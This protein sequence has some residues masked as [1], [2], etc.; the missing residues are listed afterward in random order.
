M[1]Q[2][3]GP[4]PSGMMSAWF[5]KEKAVQWMKTRVTDQDKGLWKT[6]NPGCVLC[7]EE[8]KVNRLHWKPGS[9]LRRETVLDGGFHRKHQLRRSQAEP[10]SPATNRHVSREDIQVAKRHTK[11]DSTSLI[12]REMQIKTTRS[13]HLTPGRM[14]IIKKSRNNKCWRRCGEKGTLPHC[15][16]EGKLV[17]PRWRTAWRVLKN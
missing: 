3:R 9:F 4:L 16:W 7:P 6:G 14:P 12:T 11:R 1:G 15:W 2:S 5:I 17:Q 10:E 8:D 13:Y